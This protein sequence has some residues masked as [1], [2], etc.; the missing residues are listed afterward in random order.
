MFSWVVFYSTFIDY[1]V[2]CMSVTA[3]DRS[4]SLATGRPYTC[5]RFLLSCSWRAVRV[6]KHCNELLDSIVG[7]NVFLALFLQRSPPLFLPQQQS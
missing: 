6:G 1:C 7:G 5:S 4:V 3:V 2:P